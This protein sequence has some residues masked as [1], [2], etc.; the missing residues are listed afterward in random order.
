MNFHPQFFNMLDECLIFVEAVAV[1]ILIIVGPKQS[2]HFFYASM[3]WPPV[4][5]VPVLQG[6][7]IESTNATGEGKMQMYF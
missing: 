7:Y 6:D 3:R 1:T 5:L 4:P 2:L